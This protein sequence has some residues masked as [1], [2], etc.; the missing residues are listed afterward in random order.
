[1]LKSLVVKKAFGIIRRNY[2]CPGPDHLSIQDIKYDMVS[3][4]KSIIDSCLKDCVFS[5]RRNMNIKMLR[6]LLGDI[7]EDIF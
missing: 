4:T 6:D 7:T 2:G 5:Y 1:M 3:H